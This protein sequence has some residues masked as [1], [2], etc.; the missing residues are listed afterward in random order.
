M[1]GGIPV[2]PALRM[3]KQKDHKFK[4][5]LGY[6]VRPCQRREDT[7][8]CKKDRRFFHELVM[9]KKKVP[10]DFAVVL[11]NVNVTATVLSRFISI[12]GKG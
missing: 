4:D 5:I 6:I 1:C 8:C 10:A 2:I 11:Q 3:Q 7:K 9:G 12:I